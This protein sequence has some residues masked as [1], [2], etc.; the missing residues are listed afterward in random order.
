VRPSSFCQPRVHPAEALT[1]PAHRARA[2]HQRAGRHVITGPPSDHVAHH[3]PTPP[4]FSLLPM[5]AAACPYPLQQPIAACPHFSSPSTKASSSARRRRSSAPPPSAVPRSQWLSPRCALRHR[6]VGV[7][8]PRRVDGR[9]APCELPAVRLPSPR[10]CLTDNHRTRPRTRARSTS[11]ST[12]ST[13]RASTTP[14]TASPAATRAGRRL[15][16]QP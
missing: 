13:P 9:H 3:F 1:H 4:T 5:C 7:P 16:L 11:P 6:R 10:G 14:S 15:P 2:P 8:S 12:P